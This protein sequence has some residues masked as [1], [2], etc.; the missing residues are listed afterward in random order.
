MKGI[1]GRSLA[2]VPSVRNRSS[3]TAGCIQTVRGTLRPSLS[4]KSQDEAHS[5]RTCFIFPGAHRR[6]NWQ[7]AS[8]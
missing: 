1:E 7:D 2:S 3:E 5:H 4:Q 6:H 8:H